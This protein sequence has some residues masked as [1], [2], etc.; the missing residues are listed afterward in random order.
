MAVNVLYIRTLIVLFIALVSSSE[1]RRARRWGATKIGDLSSYRDQVPLSNG[2]FFYATIYFIPSFSTDSLPSPSRGLKVKAITL[3]RGTQ[4]YTCPSNS[5]DP[6]TAVGA[7]ADLFDLSPLLQYLPN[8]EGV[9]VINE[10]PKYLINFHLATIERSPIPNLG[11]HYFDAAGV[12]TFDLGQKIGILKGK[13]DAGI[14]APKK[15][16][17]GPEGKG[18][19]AVDWLA[20]CAVAGSKRLQMGYRVETAGGKAPKSCKGQPEK[21][22]VQY[23]AQYWFYG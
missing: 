19:G 20:L 3:G 5:S 22:Q 2:V 1:A 17:K 16:S 7:V 23:A 21:I 9:H 13:R 11:H 14:A 8:S 15:A 10:L 4:N 18:G 6:P 12:P